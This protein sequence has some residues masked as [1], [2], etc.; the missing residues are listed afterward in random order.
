ML[1]PTFHSVKIS[2]FHFDSFSRYLSAF[3]RIGDC[4]F[5]NMTYGRNVL[6]KTVPGRRT[7][8]NY[9]DNINSYIT[10]SLFS[11]QFINTLNIIVNRTLY[12]SSLI[13]ISILFN[14]SLYKKGSSYSVNRKLK[15]NKLHSLDV[16]QSLIIT[17]LV[18]VFYGRTQS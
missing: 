15:W 18:K 16:I 9:E 11:S 3:A 4:S 7:H 2:S 14:D 1:T 5:L 6:V 8:D 10:C 13:L 12:V 17:L